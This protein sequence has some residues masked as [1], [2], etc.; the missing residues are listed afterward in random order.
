MRRVLDLQF[1]IWDRL[2]SSIE[3]DGDSPIRSVGYNGYAIPLG[4]FFEDAL[5]AWLSYGPRLVVLNV[6]TGTSIS[7]WTFRDRITSVSTFPTQPG[8]VPLLLVGLD[9]GANKI[10]DSMGMVCVFDCT[11]SQVL[12]AIRV[13]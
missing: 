5:Y 11:I 1:S 3:D 7:S 10:R 2:N 4:N 12:R 9:N 13:R 6:K 8:N